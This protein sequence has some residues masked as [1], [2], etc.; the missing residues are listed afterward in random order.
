MEWSLPGP[1]EFIRK[2]IGK[3]EDQKNIIFML[4][5]DFDTHSLRQTLKKAISL[6]NS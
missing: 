4:T 1:S 5:E 2:A 6:K 3:L